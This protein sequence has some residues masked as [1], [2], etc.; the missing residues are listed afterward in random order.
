MSG[1]KTKLTYGRKIMNLWIVAVLVIAF[2]GI[3]LATVTYTKGINGEIVKSEDIQPEDIQS[4]IEALKNEILTCQEQQT[5]HQNQI[6]F[7]QS[8]IDYDTEQIDKITEALK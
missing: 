3:G 5:Y 2:S 1:I 4:Q 6:N 7:L 8:K